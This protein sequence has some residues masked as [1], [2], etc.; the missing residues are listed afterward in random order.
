MST[1]LFDDVSFHYESP[2]AQV[3][4]GLSVSIDTSWR[5]GLVGRNGR[6]KTTL[7]RLLQG[8]VE[9]QRGQL[10]MPLAC[11]A[12]P[13]PVDGLDATPVREVVRA[14]VAPFTTWERR[15]DALL[16]EGGEAGLAE[17]GALAERYE[18]LGGYTID[19]RIER[20]VVRL[21][22]E[23]A[24]L[25]RPFGTLSG[26]E[27]TRAL[28]V[29]LFLREGLYPLIDEPTNHLDAAGRELLGRYLARKAGFL[30]V[31]HD[32]HFLDL[33]VD[34]VVAIEKRD[35]RVTAGS[36][37]TWKA[38]RDREEESERR[39]RGNIEREVR[40]LERAARERRS[41]SG[42]REKEKRGA[43]DKGFIGARA[44]RQ[45]KRALAVER[46]VEG[47]LAERKALLRNA[48]KERQL[49]IH[50]DQEG[51]DQI[52]AADGLRVEL[53]GRVVLRDVSLRVG[54]G[55]R[56]A[57]EGPNGCGKTTLLHVLAG[58]IAPAA[59]RVAL[60]AHLRVIRAHQTPLWQRG[61][62]R[63]QLRG[64]GID[65]SHFRG[66]MG[67]LGV[68]GEVFDRPLE[69]FSEGQRKK[70]DLCRSFLEPAHLLLW[71]E[72]LNYLDIASRE[73]IEEVVLTHAPTLV[74]VE[75]DRWFVDRVAT[76]RLRLPA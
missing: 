9:P 68:E 37:S 42:K 45:M 12:F 3:F 30:L 74:F 19:D 58:Q 69:T 56:L 21:G 67:V 51:P 11:A 25:E 46:R 65:E 60:A 32:R 38:Q 35:V 47:R 24:L 52:A 29:P 7:L 75:H 40:S 1:I 54:R 36:F 63:E 48:E 13:Y 16:A 18:A 4:D 53:G 31:S 39:R 57:I 20:E 61:S 64:A 14:A 15:M 76:E 41:W 5:T 70:V 59:G 23:P 28:I 17:Y 6:G 2:Y 49:K 44:A 26:G 55:A 72:P 33:C 8:E 66:V 71:D 22:M 10:S 34:H 27:R 62:L 43:Y 73:Q 50:G